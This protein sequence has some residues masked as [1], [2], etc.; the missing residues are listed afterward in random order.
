MI[1]V[2]KKP[3]FI[4]LFVCVFGLIAVTFFRIPMLDGIVE[5]KLKLVH[6]IQDEKLAFR[7]LFFPSEELIRMNIS[8]MSIRL[9]PIG[10]VLFVLIHFGLPLLIFLRLHFGQK[11]Q[12]A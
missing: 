10:W 6:F 5:Y 2:F 12:D 4:S 9:K 3:L 8:P 11:K 1:H 7:D